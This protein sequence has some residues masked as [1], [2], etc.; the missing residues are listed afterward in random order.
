MQLIYPF[1]NKD[2]GLSPTKPVVMAEG[3]YQAGS[4]YSFDVTPLWVRRQAYYSYLAGASHSYGHNDSWQVLPTWKAA[5]DAP[6]D[7]QMGIM[8]RIF[9]AREQWWELVPDQSVL[10]EGGQI[11]GKLLNLAARHKD[12]RW[13]MAYLAEPASVPGSLRWTGWQVREKA[14]CSTPEWYVLD[15]GACRQ[16]R[17]RELLDTD[18]VGRCSFGSQCA[19]KLKTCSK[20]SDERWRWLKRRR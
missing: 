4:E 2:Y 11:E 20:W 8:R 7:Q 1:V 5:L 10:A 9:E 15:G 19:V 13:L 6:G 16:S 18:G 3:A 14:Q 17:H 12:G